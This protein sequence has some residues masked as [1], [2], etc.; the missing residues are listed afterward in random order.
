MKNK[1]L[2]SFIMVLLL[3]FT[4]YAEED[5]FA[6][7][8][9]GTSADNADT[10]VIETTGTENISQSQADSSD[11]IFSSLDT[12]V[13][14]TGEQVL[15]PEE[16][17]GGT[18]GTSETAQTA[19]IDQ[20]FFES[21]AA[22][23]LPVT[24]TE[25]V[26]KQI[27]KRDV[28]KK[29]S[30]KTIKSEPRTNFIYTKQGNLG[31]HRKLMDHL[32]YDVKTSSYLKDFSF[33]NMMDNY[34]STAWVNGGENE[35][36]GETISFNFSEITFAPVYEKKY[37]SI[38]IREMRILN[39]FCKD[40][41][42]WEKYNRVKQFKV[43]LNNNTKYYVNLHDS[44]N[45]Q[46]VKL[47]VPI[48]IKSGDIIKLEIVDI[49]PEIRNARITNTAISEI[50]LIGGPVGPVIENKYIAENLLAE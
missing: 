18:T 26:E 47:P 8:N 29:W 5:P 44:K 17:T 10:S 38:E 50:Y 31:M 9:F 33:T 24:Q 23:P 11:D 28:K 40:E 1:I 36:I 35:G 32:K 37:K 12:E 39:G 27:V 19:E 42:F 4:V 22:T 21:T 14:Q 46:I 41:E 30:V 15:F 45:W 13:S 43:L 6:D 34:S 48:T 49:Y 20:L 7:L 25:K 2:V 3:F 16:T